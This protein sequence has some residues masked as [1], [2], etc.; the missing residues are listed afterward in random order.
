MYQKIQRNILQVINDVVA[1]FM[2]G[3]MDQILLYVNVY[4]S[5]RYYYTAVFNL[6]FQT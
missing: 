3:T 1:W 5:S 4:I 6:N 2:F